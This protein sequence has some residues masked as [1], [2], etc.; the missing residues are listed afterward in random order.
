M[1]PMT[2]LAIGGTVAGGVMQASGSAKAG[3]ADQ[4][5]SEYNARIRERNR[6]VFKQAA[7][8]RKWLAGRNSAK[9]YEDGMD[10]VIDQQVAYRKAGVATGGGTP[11][12]V[13]MEMVDR[14]E[15]KVRA[16]EYNAEAEIIALNEKG[17]NEE[18]AAHI[19]RAGSSA[20]QVARRAETAASLL[21]TAGKIGMAFI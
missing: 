9:L 12:I 16:L 4:R 5:I 21:S 13:A 8:T 17:V 11:W 1:E 2:M 10:F 7:K 14:V 6:D 3:K 18:M 19:I 20:R 15:E